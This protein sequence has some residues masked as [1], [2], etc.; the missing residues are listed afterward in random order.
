VGGLIHTL[1]GQPREMLGAVDATTGAALPF[2]PAPSAWLID[3][4]PPTYYQLPAVLELDESGGQLY[5][6]GQFFNAGGKPHSGV[7]G[8]FETTVSV[9]SLAV[10]QGIALR[11]APNPAGG[12]QALQFSLAS[13]GFARV[14]IHDVSGRVV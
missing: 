4:N 5:A 7:A 3:P 10:P 13:A 12:S 14:A 1:A 2:A 6:V 8:F 11:A 9:P